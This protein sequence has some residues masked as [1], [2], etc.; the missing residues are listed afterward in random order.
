MDLASV[1]YSGEQP[2]D[3]QQ[4]GDEQAGT[5]ADGNVREHEQPQQLQQ[6]QQPQQETAGTATAP[7]TAAAD[8]K[9][10]ARSA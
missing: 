8:M 2:D 10:G 3:S 4:E 5:K 6:P 7:G 1:R 9:M